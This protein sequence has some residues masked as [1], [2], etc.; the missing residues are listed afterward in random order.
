M[1]R[2]GFITLVGG[3]AGW[4]VGSTRATAGNTGEPRAARRVGSR[5]DRP[6]GFDSTR[7]WVGRLSRE[8]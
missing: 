5:M 1:G 6:H 4:A 8:S 3:A 2:R 7:A